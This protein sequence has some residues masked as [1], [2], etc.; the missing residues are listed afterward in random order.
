MV[1]PQTVSIPAAYWKA[2]CTNDASFDEKFFYGVQ[3]TGI[4]C[5][6]S[7]K[8]RLPKKENVRIFKNAFAALKADYRPCKRCKPDGLVLPAAEWVE[9]IAEWLDVHFTEPATLERLAEI[10][11]GSP[12]HLQRLFKRFKGVSPSEYVQKLRL[13]KAA[14][15]LKADTLSVTE[16]GR[17][18]GFGNTAY[19]ITLFKKTNGMTPGQFRTAQK[20]F[21]GAECHDRQRY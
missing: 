3:S 1:E 5:R 12:H 19:F 4:F 14:E 17:E 9:Q 10:S 16:A 13:E 11:H 20:K 18:A 21:K 6:P 8:S 15:L 2:I 7:C